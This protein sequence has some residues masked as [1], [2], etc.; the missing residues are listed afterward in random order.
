MKNT[1]QPHAGEK[2]A[3]KKNKEYRKVKAIKDEEKKQG[4]CYI[5]IGDFNARLLRNDGLNKENFRKH[6]LT[7]D[8]EITEINR[9][10]WDNRERVV[11]FVQ[12]NELVAM[13]TVFNKRKKTG[14][15]TRIKTVG[16]KEENHGTRQI[17]DR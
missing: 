6:F 5:L 12:E 10:V 11:E 2:N 16:I 3:D 17:M 13:N 1:Y 8:K 14:V 4:N 15:R 7:T 9:D